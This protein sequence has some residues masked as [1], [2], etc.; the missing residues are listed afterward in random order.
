MTCWAVHSAVGCSVTLKWTRRRRSWARMSRTNSTVWVTVGTTKKCH[1]P[2]AFRGKGYHRSSKAS[3][4]E[5][6]QVEEP[7]SCGDC[8]SFHFYAT[9]AGMLSAPLVGH[10]MIQMGQSSQERLLAPLGM[11][12]AFH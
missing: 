11:I 5:D 1:I 9:A 4:R 10:E 6:L 2:S 8:S 12:E 3:R 7:V